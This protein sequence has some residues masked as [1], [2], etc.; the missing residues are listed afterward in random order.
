MLN[1]DFLL[2]T[3]EREGYLEKR[4]IHEE[5][6]MGAK[7]WGSKTALIEKDVTV[8][9]REL[10]QYADVLAQYFEK[11]GLFKGDK[12]LLQLPN[13]ILYVAVLLGLM[14]AGVIP[15]LLLPSHREKEIVR[16]SGI[17]Q[18]KAYIGTGDY[19][20]F[21]YIDMAARI[22]AVSFTMI[23]TD[24]LNDS[25][26]GMLDYHVLPLRTDE[27]REVIPVNTKVHYRDTALFLLSGGTTDMPKIIPR[28]HEAYAYNAKASAKRCEVN[29]ESVYLAVLSTSHDLPLA[30]PGLLGTL[31]SGGTVVLCESASFE[32]A[33]SAIERHKVTLTAIVPAIAKL[34]AEVLTW[35]QGDFTN[36]KQIIIGAAKLD[37]DIGQR[38]MEYM[39]VKIQQGYGL[40]EGLTCFTRLSD[41]DDVCLNTQGTPISEGDHIKIVDSEGNQLQ[42]YENGE[43]LEKGPYTFMGYYGNPAMN[44]ASFDEDGY[45]WTGDKGYLDDRGNVILTGRVKEQINRAGENVIPMEI[46]TLLGEH[47]DIQD[48]AVFGMPD[49]LLGERTAAAVISVNDKLCLQ[50]ILSFFI[51][52][53]VARYKVPDEIFLVTSFPYTNVGKVDKNVLKKQLEMSKEIENHA[54]VNTGD[55]K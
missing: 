39:G 35:Y 41:G 30:S 8:T 31:L 36:L 48:A 38:L 37:S 9:Y 2:E 33:F 4:T 12:V 23:F 55:K 21:D 17:T 49:E 32:E 6:L 45:F 54:K 14:K 19:I 13:R 7:Q 5:F 42:P 16:I 44:A 34:W 50:D 11:A 10:N 40:G 25:W 43:I 18:P 52:R 1:K 29:R 20:G 22:D 47:Q 26:R 24:M 27:I 15:I 3:Y 28:I 51:S 46:E 53:G